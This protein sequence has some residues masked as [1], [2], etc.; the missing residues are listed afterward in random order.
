MNVNKCYKR[1]ANDLD[2][3]GINAPS[4]PG[5]T[6]NDILEIGQD[7]E[8][9]ND[10]DYLENF[11]IKAASYNTFLK[12]RKGSIEA[13]TRILNC[14]FERIMAL[15]TSRIDKGLYLTKEEKKALVLSRR[16][17][18]KKDMQEIVMLQAE[19]DRIKDIPFAIDK[20]LEILKLKY[21]RRMLDEQKQES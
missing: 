16:E 18:L 21:R 19:F 13:R 8:K 15:E 17:D 3:M 1:I 2:S 12:S 11:L 4:D 14:E 5:L 10:L 9:F 6:C 7:K 20:T